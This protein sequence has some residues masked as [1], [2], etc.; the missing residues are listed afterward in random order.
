MD[1]KEAAEILLEIKAVALNTKEPY[2][3]ASGI[4]SPIYTD[5]RLL[6][7]YPEKRKEITNAMAELAKGKG[8]EFDVVAGTAT[9]GIPHAAWLADLTQKPMVYVRS[10]E[11][12]HGRENKIEGLVKREWKA[13]AIEDLI[14]TGG[15]SVNTVQG[16]R[17]AGIEANHIIAIFTYGM[18]KAKKRFKEERI[19]LHALTN[20]STMIETAAEKG[21]ISQEEKKIAMEWNKDP[22]NWGKRHGFE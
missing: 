6:M 17:E 3:Y 7:G 14:S 19:K 9:A 15:S 20:F 11:K 4:I 5:N 13:L 12:G 21:K 18:E 16:L 10:K 2:R 1:K 22:A 8:I